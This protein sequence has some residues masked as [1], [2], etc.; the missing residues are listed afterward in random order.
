MKNY[1]TPLGPNSDQIHEQH[2]N[3]QSRYDI[4]FSRNPGN[5]IGS[6]SKVSDVLCRLYFT[7]KFNFY[8]ASKM[9]EQ[10]RFIVN[11]RHAL[12]EVAKMK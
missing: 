7:W 5:P 1:I 3:I 11:L 9:A 12:P 10:S 6:L 4:T 2:Y 8:G